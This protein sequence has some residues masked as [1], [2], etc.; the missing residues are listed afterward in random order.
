MKNPLFLAQFSGKIEGQDRVSGIKKSQCKSLIG[1]L[2]IDKRLSIFRGRKKIW[3]PSLWG[4]VHS[5]VLRDIII[6]RR[7]KRF[8]I[9]LYIRCCV[10]IFA[11][12]ENGH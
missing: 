2:C 11:T 8:C 9:L 12:P 6:D 4:A 1:K 7:K 10:A 5:L 3:W